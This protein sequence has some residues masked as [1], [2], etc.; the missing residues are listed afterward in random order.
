MLFDVFREGIRI[1]TD[2][3]YLLRFLRAKKF[4]HD[5]AMKSIHS[6]YAMKRDNKSVFARMRPSEVKH[7]LAAETLLVLPQ[8]DK[9]GRQVMIFKPS[10]AISN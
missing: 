8:R 2:D 5:R 9:E 10:K 3:A 4:D 7:V 6:H 1:R